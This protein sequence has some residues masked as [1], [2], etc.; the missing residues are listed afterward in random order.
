MLSNKKKN[1]AGFL[2]VMKEVLKSWAYIYHCYFKVYYPVKGSGNNMYHTFQSKGLHD[3]FR[4]I[5]LVL[6]IDKF[7]PIT[8]NE[9]PEGE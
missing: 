3:V 4:E 2:A 1:R 8:A 7:R 9:G 6:R 5:Q